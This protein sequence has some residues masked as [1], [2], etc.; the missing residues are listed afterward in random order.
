MAD[1]VPEMEVVVGRESVANVLSQ[2]PAGKSVVC[3]FAAVLSQA[4]RLRVYRWPG[5]PPR[6]PS[7]N[8]EAEVKSANS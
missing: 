2:Q 7:I 3:G 4:S 1:I 6:K 5:L 8:R